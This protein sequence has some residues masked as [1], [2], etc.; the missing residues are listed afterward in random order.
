MRGVFFAF[1]LV[2]AVIVLQTA[3]IPAFLPPVLRPDLGLLVGVTALAFA[4]QEFALPLLFALGL[5][6][7]LF[8]SPRLGLLTLSYLLTA[9]LLL[10]SVWRELTRGD[11][12]AAWI[13]GVA[14]TL[15]AHLCYILIA[16]FC[17]LTVGL[18]QACATLVS[19][20]LAAALWGLPC[21]YLCGRLLFRLGLLTGA[22]RERWA[23]Q[24]RLAA[25]RKGKLQKSRF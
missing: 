22:S 24:A 17:G 6:A 20:T 10:F 5:Q 2:L 4:P 14:A 16:R 15:L 3:V 1:F 18:G 11:V 21:A 9:G 25:A 7:D 19:L 13:G 8:G 23:A 12:L